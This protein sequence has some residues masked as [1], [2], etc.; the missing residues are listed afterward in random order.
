[1]KRLYNFG[2]GPA[3]MPQ[4]VLNQARKDL[5]LFKDTGMG[6]GEISHRSKIFEQILEE[7]KSDLK[8]LMKLGDGYEIL[9]L[10]GGA[11]SH[12]NLIP[13]NF[14]NKNDKASFIDTG[15]WTFKAMEACKF[16]AEVDLIASSK[17]DSYKK[18][19]NFN[20]KNIDPRSKYLYICTNNTIHGTRYK[21]EKLPQ[22]DLSLVGDMSSH[23]LS[24]AYPYKDFD[25]FFASAQK[26][27]GLPGL[28]L[29]VIKKEFLKKAKDD[30]PAMFSYKALA[31]KNSLINTPPTFNIYLL[32]L[33]L[34]WIKSV[35]GIEKIEN[36]NIKKAKTLYDFLDSSD[37]FNNYVKKEDK[38]LM[39]VIFTT[40]DKNLDIKFEKL[41]EKQGL[42]NLKGH[43]SVG[44]L[45][46]SIYN[47][48]GLDGVESLVNFMKDFEMKNK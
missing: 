3:Q 33:I 37:L 47:A 35:G 17:K 9:F 27:L 38:S 8:D 30:L 7:C 43:R 10:Q 34:K 19:P 6:I 32:N 20:V 46:A 40:G 25:L 1:M 13:M 23:I 18:I 4:E 41:A 48:M 15:S 28:T 2:P 42:L 39:N 24:E 26:N 12:F 21:K 16:F 36:T 5:I 44:G 11:S 29:V 22:T 45:R 31:E 14:L